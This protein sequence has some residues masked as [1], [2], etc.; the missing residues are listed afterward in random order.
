MP[1]PKSRSAIAVPTLAALLTVT[2]FACSS[3]STA[4]TDDSADGG[5]DAALSTAEMGTVITGE[6]RCRS[7]SR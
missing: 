1:K 6:I 7:T 4:A 3:K 5:S 2:S